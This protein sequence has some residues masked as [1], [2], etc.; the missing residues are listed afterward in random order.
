MAVYSTNT[1]YAEIEGQVRKNLQQEY[2]AIE[3]VTLRAAELEKIVTIALVALS[4]HSPNL[5][6]ILLAEAESVFGKKIGMK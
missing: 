2:D 6:S 1:S 3:R 4:D 5:G